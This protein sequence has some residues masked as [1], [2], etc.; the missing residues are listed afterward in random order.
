MSG[1]LYRAEFRAMGTGC[2]VAVSA[3]AGEASRGRRALAAA[4][5]EIEACERDLS[6]FLPTSDLSRLNTAAGEWSP[7]GPR[8]IGALGA[9]LRARAV[10]GGRFDPTVLPAL[11]AAGYDRPFDRLVP[12]PARPLAGWRAGAAV[13]VDSERGRARVATGAA[14]DLGGIGK[15]W[16]AA[17]ALEAMR[18]AWTEIPGALV[19]LGGDVAV[20]GAPP[21]GGP[22]RVAVADPRGAAP[23]LGTLL[24]EGGG[25]A[26][27]G[28]DRRRFGPGRT[29]HHLID[30]RTG[31]PTREG[32]LAVTV[33][34]PDPAEAEAEATALAVIPSA[35]AALHL[36]GRPHLSALVVPH[37]G[38]PLAIGDLPLVVP[39]AERAVA[40]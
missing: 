23:S 26:T 25:V 39:E 7:A 28:R 34:G 32:P 18:E 12:R 10:T 13:E 37:A 5:R 8:L 15:G 36:A 31:A 17:R 6:R 1:R 14:V 21:E 22:W 19:D 29:L 33:V 27:S 2:A 35:A 40:R 3:G 20:W 16:S 30:P 38:P 11:V 24:L 4:R 9:A